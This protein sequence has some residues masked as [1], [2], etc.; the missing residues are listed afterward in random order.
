MSNGRP[1]QFLL[2]QGNKNAELCY[3][4]QHDE[5]SVVGKQIEKDP[6]K[7]FRINKG[8]ADWAF[9]NQ[10][11]I[12][13]NGSHA[14]SYGSSY[15]VSLMIT[16]REDWG[17]EKFGPFE[18]ARSEVVKQNIIDQLLTPGPHNGFVQYEYAGDRYWKKFAKTGFGTQ[19]WT[20]HIL[21][22]YN[23]Q[24]FLRACLT[25]TKGLSA[26][27]NLAL[28]YGQGSSTRYPAFEAAYME[29]GDTKTTLLT[30]GD[31]LM[32]I[33]GIHEFKCVNGQISPNMGL[34]ATQVAKKVPTNLRI[35]L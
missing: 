18:F 23:P 3:V 9:R 35:V 6:E 30:K 1:K 5:Y 19:K 31:L 16:N 33:F 13:S 26:T 17:I 28:S 24:Q 2:V 14:N 12:G 4:S 21:G 25:I 22:S 34:N 10:Q 20:S 7:G 27:T 29:W 11:N 32:F 15:C 8:K